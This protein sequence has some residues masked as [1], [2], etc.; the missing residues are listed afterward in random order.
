M[1]DVT[2]AASPPPA[3]PAPPAAPAPATRPDQ[4]G[5]KG[6]V[7]N[8]PPPV[9]PDYQ[10]QPPAAAPST[11]P[12]SADDAVVVLPSRR[13]ET[14]EEFRTGITRH[15]TPPDMWVHGRPSLQRSWE[16]ARY[17][18]HVPDDEAARLGARIVIGATIPV[19]AVLLY[20]DWLLEHPS[21]FLVA[22]VLVVV[23][24]QIFL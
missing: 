3:P 14:F 23:A 12:A 7:N 4:D 16:W 15:F 11:D 2:A 8:E 17:G 24:W 19:R 22:A 21:R 9:R 5:R 10:K 6:W 1:T 18:R 13:P 20:L